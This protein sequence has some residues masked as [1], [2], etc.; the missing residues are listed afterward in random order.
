MKLQFM[1]ATLSLAFSAWAQA[2]QAAEPVSVDRMCG[3]LVSIGGSRQKG[4][5]NS[6]QQEVKTVSHARLQLFSPSAN[7]DCCALMTPVAEAVTGRD[8]E[9]QFKRAEPGDY[10]LV[11]SIGGTAYKLLVR[12]EPGIQK[13][14]SDCSAFEYALLKGELQLVR[15]NQKTVR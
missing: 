3:K 1:V 12:Y 15:A 2:P 13:S 7:A 4:T 9:F 10:W 8:G 11:A 6:S 14:G 5:A